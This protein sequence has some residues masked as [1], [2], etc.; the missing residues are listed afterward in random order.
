MLKIQFYDSIIQYGDWIVYSGP[1]SPVYV[2]ELSTGKIVGHTE[3]AR[4]EMSI[5]VYRDIL[6][7]PVYVSKYSYTLMAYRIPSM[8]KSVTFSSFI[9]L[10]RFDA[11]L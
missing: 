6:Y 10:S 11:D 3:K 5:T 8:K 2:A 1:G 7:L 4:G 9:R